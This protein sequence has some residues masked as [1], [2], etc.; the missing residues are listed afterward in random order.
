MDLLVSFRGNQNFKK[1]VRAIPS[2]V[3]L[4]T[5]LKSVFTY[6]EER[7]WLPT[8]SAGGGGFT[9]ILPVVPLD[10]EEAAAGKEPRSAGSFNRNKDEPRVNALCFVVQERRPMCFG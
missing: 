7:R 2:R 5:R 6:I 3:T 10:W 4:G 1:Y 9:P 8:T